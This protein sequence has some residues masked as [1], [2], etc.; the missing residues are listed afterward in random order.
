[1]NAQTG[2]SY[3]HTVS[4]LSALRGERWHRSTIHTWI[5]NI[6][7]KYRNT[8]TNN[9]NNNNNNYYYYYNDKI[10]LIVIVMIIMTVIINIGTK[11]AECSLHAY[12]QEL[13]N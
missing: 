4:S 1:M 7:Q 3:F 8:T 12:K 9:N 6:S 2:Q 10:L 13:Q 5:S 11:K